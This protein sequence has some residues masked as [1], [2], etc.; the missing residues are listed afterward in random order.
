MTVIFRLTE[1][2]KKSIEAARIKYNNYDTWNTDDTNQLRNLIKDYCIKAQKS[3]CCYC[4]R[5]I[6]TRNKSLWDLDHIIPRATHPKFTFE[7]LNIVASCRDCN[8]IK[9]SSQTL[10]N[11]SRKRL[12]T[13]S[14]DYKIVHPYLDDYNDHIGL[15]NIVYFAKSAK[16]RAT[17]EMCGL[18][19]FTVDHVDWDTD[20]TDDRFEDEFSKLYNGTF[21]ESKAALDSLKKVIEI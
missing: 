5:R 2:D 3:T 13:S 15:I 11:K 17:I 20:P 21:N 19:R 16:G 4:S 18:L 12:P 8:T 6:L 10:V 14:S 1:E 7:P 9:S